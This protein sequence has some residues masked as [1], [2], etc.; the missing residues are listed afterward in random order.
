MT[1]LAYPTKKSRLFYR[2]TKKSQ[3]EICEPS[4]QFDNPLSGGHEGVVG[5]HERARPPGDRLGESLSAGS[6]SRP[7][8]ILLFFLAEG[9]DLLIVVSVPDGEYGEKIAAVGVREIKA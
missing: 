7:R 4:A 2:Y 8:G 9:E 3:Y 1:I 6:S 5:G